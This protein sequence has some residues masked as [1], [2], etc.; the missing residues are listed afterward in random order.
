MSSQ[1][2]LDAYR[3]LWW[4]HSAPGGIGEEPVEDSRKSAL[5]S[6]TEALLSGSDGESGLLPDPLTLEERIRH[7]SS[8]PLTKGGT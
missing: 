8:L 3:K 4:C 6:S 7:L 2:R 1:T 5:R